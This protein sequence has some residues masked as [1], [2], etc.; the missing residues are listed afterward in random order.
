MSSNLLLPFLRLI[1][2]RPDILERCDRAY[3]IGTTNL[4]KG[5][6][7]NAL[8]IDRIREATRGAETGNISGVVHLVQGGLA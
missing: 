1:V 6:F 5:R 4:I 7:H 8:L 2:P 3:D